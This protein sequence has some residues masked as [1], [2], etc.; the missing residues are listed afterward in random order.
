MIYY[1]GNGGCAIALPLL[2]LTIV[3]VIWNL[4]ELPSCWAVGLVFFLAGV[5]LWWWGRWLNKPLEQASESQS[6]GTEA[7]HSLYGIE[8]EYWGAFYIILGPALCGYDLFK[9]LF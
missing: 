9:R 2:L 8:M 1:R 7:R 3:C 6:E 4:K 5:I